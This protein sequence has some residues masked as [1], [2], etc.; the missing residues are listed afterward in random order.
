MKLFN[1]LKKSI[2]SIEL[3]SKRV[4][5]MLII[6]SIALALLLISLTSCNTET[7]DGITQQG[8]VNTA[9]QSADSVW[10]W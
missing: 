6:T 5:F 7:G 9:T 3:P 8:I 1:K 10:V 4:I 2:K